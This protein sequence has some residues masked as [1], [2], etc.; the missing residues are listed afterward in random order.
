MKKLSVLFVAVV[1]LMMGV[2]AEA[3]TIINPNQINYNTS[4][5]SFYW[6]TGDLT[7]GIANADWWNDAAWLG[8]GPS[9]YLTIDFDLGGTYTLDSVSPTYVVVSTWSQWA[10]VQVDLTFSNDG[11]NFGNLVTC[12]SFTNNDYTANTVS[13]LVPNVTCQYVKAVLTAPA[14][15]QWHRLSEFTFTAVPEPATLSL[16]GIGLLALVRRKK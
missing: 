3:G 7:D 10:P 16:L 8:F 6:L 9:Q 13:I 15:A 12:T 5:G 4:M 11:T 2:N 14:D 1:A